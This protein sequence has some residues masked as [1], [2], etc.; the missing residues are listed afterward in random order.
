MKT[1]YY[2]E[3]KNTEDGWFYHIQSKWFNTKQQALKWYKDSFDFIRYE[4]TIV[5]LMSAKF[6]DNGEYGDINNVE[7]LKPEI[8]V[9]KENH[10]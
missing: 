3:F 2:V 10:I 5:W 8:F 6:D 7:E 1:K 9:N 4:T